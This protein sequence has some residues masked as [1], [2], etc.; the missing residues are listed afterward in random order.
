MVDPGRASGG[1]A[2]GIGVYEDSV[3]EDPIAGREMPADAG[4]GDLEET[5]HRPSESCS[6][7]AC[8]WGS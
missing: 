2:E 4:V 6:D 1:E 7:D 8:D 3:G 5:E